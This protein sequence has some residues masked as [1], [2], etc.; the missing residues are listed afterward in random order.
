MP[1][2][3]NI[4][5]CG[6]IGLLLL[7]SYLLFA[8]Y[9]TRHGDFYQIRRWKAAIWSSVLMSVLFVV[10][11]IIMFVA[12][13]VFSSPLLQNPVL[14]FETIDENYF[15]IYTG[16]IAAFLGFF[17]CLTP[18][19]FLTTIAIHYKITLWLTSDDFLDKIWKDPNRGHKSPI[20]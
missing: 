17:P 14:L 12:I 1:A 13:F 18:Y 20:Q 16:I 11:M 19:L 15:Q 10:I 4:V 2:E 8:F 9:I 7:V 3:I 5:F 6:G